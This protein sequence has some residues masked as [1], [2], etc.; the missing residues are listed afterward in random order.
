[1]LTV[2][3]VV[4]QIVNQLRLLDP[5]VS[6]EIGTPERKIIEATAELI[7]SQQVDFSILNEQ[8]NLDTMSGGRLDAYLSI[9]NFGRQQATPA[10]GT[11]TFSR[12]V[13]GTTAVTIPRGTQVLANIDDA[14]FPSIVFVTTETVVLDAGT[15]SVDA[16][17]Q[18][19]I[20]GTI[21]NIDANKVVGFGG[22]KSI[23]GITSI[24]NRHA[25]TGGTDAE[26]DGA[27]K[28][29]FQR[30]FLR[31]VSG[32]TD[33]FLALA[34]SANSV[35]KANVVGPMSRYQEYM[36][37][38]ATRDTA[39]IASGYDTT[40]ATYPHKRTTAVSTIPY[41][42]YTYLSNYY[43]TDGTLDPATATFFR[44][45]VDYIFNSPPVATTA[46]GTNE[47]Q[48][49]TESVTGGTYTLSF[50]GFVTA[51][52][53]HNAN[54]AAIEAALLALPNLTTG[55]VAVTGGA[56]PYTITFGG[57][58]RYVN[59]PAIVVDA[60]LA[61]GGTVVITT[62][63][64]GVSG[65]Q[66]NTTPTTSPNITFLNPYDAASNPN[67]NPNLVAGSVYLAEHAYLSVNSRNDYSYG[68]LNAVDVFVNG[69]KVASA[70]ST[71]S[72]PYDGHL[73]QNTVATAWT[74]QKTTATK[75]INFRRKLDGNESTVGNLI[76]P[77]YWQPV[78]DLPDSIQIGSGTY[79]KANY[80]NP[81]DGI[82]Y[83][84]FDGTTYS[85]KAHY[86]LAEEVNSNYGTIRCRN[87][88]E[89]FLS[90]SNF[91]GALAVG[92]VGDAYTGVTIDTLVGTTFTIEDYL[93]DQN[94]SDLQA[95]MEK[96]KQTT[97]D[98]LVHR[99]K[100]RYYVPIVTVMY[101]I[102]AT[103]EVV[104]AAIVANLDNFFQNQYYGAAIQLSD[105]LQAIH[106]T[107]GVDNV[108]WTN[109]AGNK[110]IEVAQDGST[111]SG[112]PYYI[113]NDFFIQD[114]ELAASPS[115]DS[116]GGNATAVIITVR[117][118]NTWTT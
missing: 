34:V 112:G 51:P 23:V 21:G 54:A 38:P 95:V 59:V 78:L 61:T 6:A 62:P 20:A 58:Y 13:A 43:L 99:A 75:V 104:N 42:K 80:L 86:I 77:L 48:T 40:G 33:M 66:V 25:M 103:I 4:Q 41:S 14:I 55:D 74:Y 84:R 10:Y 81:A 37:V 118:Q 82:Y 110:L 85:F 22:L 111:L 28:T 44:P 46:T 3:Q 113:T 11:V 60:A 117:A 108:R 97:Q 32:T 63:T 15:A 71:E 31:N 91:L 116:A 52:I 9:F 29:R 24:S 72:V 47:I 8:H 45:G 50:D 107:P 114:S 90:G 1:M 83:N 65:A 115:H 18:C 12:N 76:Q 64:P 67:G 2:D 89:W 87:G 106:N 88:I 96:N 5:T 101:T 100:Q 105:I 30:T 109:E 92:D 102:G 26:D 94:I 98:V 7:A 70:S 19:T 39:L 68:I 56:S 73:L 35:T 27:Y 69:S 17:V 36:Q 53:A 57:E 49:L 79:F 16:T 93:Y